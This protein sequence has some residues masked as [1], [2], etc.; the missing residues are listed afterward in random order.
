MKSELTIAER[1]FTVLQ[2]ALLG[3]A[4][5][6]LCSGCARVVDE[7]PRISYGEYNE[8]VGPFDW[9]A[10]EKPLRTFDLRLLAIILADFESSFSRRGACIA[11][12]DGGDLTYAVVSELKSGPSLLRVAYVLR[13]GEKGAW[14]KFVI[15]DA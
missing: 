5:I 9:S 10:P 1:R 2:R 8:R 4:L 12:L 13:R 11:W 3:S 14:R 6:L 7:V 15:P